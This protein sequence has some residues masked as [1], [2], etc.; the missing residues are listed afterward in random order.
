[1]KVDITFRG[2]DYEVTLEETTDGWTALVDG[3]EISLKSSASSIIAGNQVHD[4]CVA[5]TTAIIDGNDEQF[6]INKLEGVAGAFVPAGGK[7]GPVKPPMTGKLEELLVTNGQAV[8][9]GDVLF[10]L[11]AMKM[12]NEIKAPISGVVANISAAVGDALDSSNTVL[13]LKSE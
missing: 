2:K 7:H 10:V 8:E 11:E 1:M 5:G 4:I 12:R 9:Q 13:E 3:T 6:Y